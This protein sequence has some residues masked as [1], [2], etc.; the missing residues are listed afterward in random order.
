MPKA[1]TSGKEYRTMREAIE[2]EYWP[3]LTAISDE[4]WAKRQALLNECSA[5]LAALDAQQTKDEKEEAPC[6]TA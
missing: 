3:K 1:H 5:K 4:Y 6:P 2:N